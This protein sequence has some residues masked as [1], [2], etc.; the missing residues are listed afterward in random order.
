MAIPA[1]KIAPALGVRQYRR[2]QAGGFGA[3]LRLGDSAE[4]LAK[5]GIPAGVFNL[6][7]GRGSVVGETLV[8][9]PDVAAISFTGSVGTGRGI[10]AKAIARMAKIQL[11]MG[12]KNP[13]VV[14]DDADLERCRQRGGSGRILFDGPAL[15]RIVAAHRHRRHS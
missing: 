15:H 14:V 6:V 8:T 3:R 11:E 13:L 5:S 10:A 12:G 7:M 9:H 2:V 1:W 4:I